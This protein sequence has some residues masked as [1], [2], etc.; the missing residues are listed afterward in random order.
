MNKNLPYDPDLKE[1]MLKI[2]EIM[3]EYEIGGSIA[4]ASKTHAEFLYHFPKWSIVQL[5]KPSGVRIRSKREDFSSK[6][7]QHKANEE[8]CHLVARTRDSSG[9]AFMVFE[10]IFKQLDKQFDIEHEPFSKFTPHREN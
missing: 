9:K 7:A 6:E 2:Q 10:D 8:T 3:D 4:L 1:A 5:V